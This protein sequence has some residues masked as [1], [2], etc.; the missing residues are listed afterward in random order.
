MNNPGTR[1]VYF[2]LVTICL[3]GVDVKA[4][5]FPA[6]PLVQMP[7]TN[8]QIAINFYEGP[9]LISWIN[10]SDDIY[11]LYVQQ[12]YPEL[13]T[14]TMITSSINPISYPTIN[15]SSWDYTPNLKLVWSEYDSTG[16]SL[17]YKGYSDDSWDETIQIV[18]GAPNPI[19]SSA[20]FSGI[21][22]TSEGSLYYIR[23]IESFMDSTWSSPT[24]IDS[25][26]C[27]NPV[28]FE[29]YNYY[30]EMAYEKQ[31]G[32]SNQIKKC[33]WSYT[34]GDFIFET[35]STVPQN[36]NPRRGPERSL[37][38]ES[39]HDSTWR[40]TYTWSWYY[41]DSRLTSN[42]STNVYNPMFL[43]VPQPVLNLRETHL[44]DLLV[45]ES[46]SLDDG[47]EI[48]GLMNSYFDGLG[49]LINISNL[50]GND[51]NPAIGLYY[52]D[53][54]E[55]AIFWEHEVDGGSEIWWA[56]S[57][58]FM[59]GGSVDNGTVLP[60]LELFEN[61]PNPFNAS[62]RIKY[63]LHENQNVGLNIWNI[64]GQI[65]ASDPV[66]YQSAGT[67]IFEWD[68]KSLSS[69]VYFYS[70]YSEDTSLTKKC[71]LVK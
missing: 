28:I 29:D 15:G 67:H 25:G 48:M 32:D 26:G 34:A 71:L 41:S 38:F 21:A 42:Q 19:K 64:K 50:A 17:N 20:G 57:R 44:Y 69:G 70:L 10:Y 37:S 51:R 4:E 18:G 6:Q 49:E 68:T 1:T 27:D 23:H 36:R 8:T 47:L 54:I 12:I 16:W 62:T 33:A 53:S 14:P 22:W 9:S 58:F 60:K 52:E 13:A 3:M 40:A 59:Q 35:I 43:G 7:G 66:R 65:V 30:L 55:V 31:V 39:F 46:D 56:T 45:F 24:L 2:L 11:S 5:L 63:E 61:Y